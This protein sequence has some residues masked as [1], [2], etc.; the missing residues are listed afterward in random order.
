MHLGASPNAGRAYSESRGKELWKTFQRVLE[1]CEEEKVELLLIAGD[2]FHRQPLVRELKEA[3]YLFGKLT[4]TQVVLIAG[5][6][7]YIKNNSNYLTY[8]WSPNVHFL[9]GG[10]MKCVELEALSTRV[11]GF[12]YHQKEILEA[13][14][15]K[16][17][18]P[19]KAKIEILLAHGGDDRHIPFQK[20]KLLLQ[21][22]DYVALG[23]IHKPE[24]FETK[25]AAYAGALEPTD[26]NDTGEHG[27]ILG[28]VSEE[29][30]E[31]EFVPFATREYKHLEIEVHSKMTN[32]EVAALVEKTVGR[33]GQQHLYRLILTGFRDRDIFF[34]TRGM[35]TYG[36]ILEIL[37]RTKPAY[38]F[39]RLREQNKENL[40]GQFIKE[41]E[42]FEKDSIEYQAL[43]EGVHA[44]ME[45]KRG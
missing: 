43:Y 31:V 25:R 1:V 42:C 18:A 10:Q 44:L 15:D 3:D 17:P 16:A 23:H 9:S 29:G 19:G 40:L 35:D 12:S 26:T 2:L 13:K 24:I 41:M 14:Y 32:G 33:N 39:A 21:G 28:E 30:I 5:N 7:D 8:K 6:H 27:Y 20:E 36:N 34:D 4:N 45:T 38:D 22:Y 37:D 11:Y